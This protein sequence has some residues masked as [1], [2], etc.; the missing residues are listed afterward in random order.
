MGR[1]A[2]LGA[3]GASGRQLLN[4]ALEQGHDIVALCRNP[5]TLKL[6]HEKLQV[7]IAKT[8]IIMEFNV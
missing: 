8:T 2:V 5:T 4:L 3:T 7:C 6:N 1:F